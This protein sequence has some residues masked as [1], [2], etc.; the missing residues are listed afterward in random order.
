MLIRRWNAAT[1]PQ[2]LLLATIFLS[3]PR[4]AETQPGL[5]IG[6][7]GTGL[8]SINYGG[9]EFLANGDFRLNEVAFLNADSTVTD[10]STA[11][12]VTVDANL[13]TQ[14]RA[15]NW[16]SIVTS[17]SIV[18]SNQLRISV[19]VNNQT[20]NTIQRIWM[21]PLSVHF[22]SSP[23]EFGPGYPLITDTVQQPAVQ[24]MTYNGGLLVVAVDD[25][26][27]PLQIGFPYS[28]D[29][30]ANTIFPLTLNTDR[31]ASY[32]D[33]FRTINRP[34]PG[35]SS[36]TFLFSL[37]FGGPGS[38]PVSLASDV[39]QNFAAAFPP[40]M[41]WPDRRA[42]ASLH[43]A[44]WP[45]G[46]A[47][48]ATNPRGWFNDPSV[49]VTTAAGVANFQQRLLAYADYSIS[50]LNNMNAQGMITWDIEGEQ[51]PGFVGDPTIMA[52]VAPEMAGIADAY[53]AKFR[54][55]GFRVGV[56]VRPEQVILSPDGATIQE[57]FVSDQL[58][59]L[60]PKIT[61]AH[62]RWGA[63]LFYIDSNIIYWNDQHPIDR[64]I[65]ET[66][67]NLFPDSLFIP[68]HSDA[69]YWAY[70]APYLQLDQGFT[71]TPAAVRFMYPNAFTVIST[72]DGAIQQN[73][74]ALVTAVQQGDVLLFRG[75]F[76]DPQNAL[77]A[78]IYQ[79]AGAS[80]PLV[81]SVTP[82]FAAA[83]PGQTV[84]LAAT[85]AGTANQ[86]VTWTLDS[87]SAGS[88]S[89]AGLYTSPASIAGQQIATVRATS[90]ADGTK[91]ATAS[92]TVAPSVAVSL[93]P[94]G[95]SIGPNQLLQ[96]TAAVAGNT[97]Q[98]VTWSLLS[99]PG[100]L[101]QSGLYRAP[102]SI[103]AQ[104]TV[105][106]EATSSADQTKSATATITLLPAFSL[107]V[108]PGSGSLSAGQTL[109]FTSSVT[110]N[111]N[112]Q[113]TWS[114]APAGLG[115]IS[116]S[117]LYTAPSSIGAQQT[118]TVRATSVADG[119]KF[120]SAT[121]TLNP[122]VGIS[123]APNTGSLSAGQTLQFTPT[124][125]GSGNQQVTWNIAPAGLGIISSS[126]LYQAPSAVASQ[127]SVT[128]RP[129]A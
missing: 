119:T 42:I 62:N 60:L 51:F 41:F 107:S 1:A 115:I 124:V 25:L 73:F 5:T 31:V 104:Q 71:S 61:Y 27:K 106:V 76:N 86:S 113:V 128:I 111:A 102:V 29:G 70:S 38:T 39:Y 94:Q 87:G 53:F 118:V 22:P 85:V 59:A 95:E 90:G 75:W 15:Y 2:L 121:I 14:T 44:S 35:N 16:G 64:L 37:R 32:C 79:A 4:L 18:G 10:G 6:F 56:A 68:E 30:P 127:Q 24:P 105:T 67:H 123:L 129:R 9:T 110:G 81:V 89:P 40:T 126:G 92:I 33:C 21:E 34:I 12:T 69:Q 84:Q 20:P 99:G 88:L 100:S 74:N 46:S 103:A 122:A 47:A 43:I 17:Y 48:Y 11:S 83:G 101:S 66:L 98:Q 3:V 97:N 55:A 36:D 93:L 109:Q 112:Q 114:I 23:P 91:S 77:D 54:N 52:T 82:Q 57:N 65:F 80:A 28:Y 26:L 50:I 19:T 72:A 63:T 120:A 78:S 108:S 96:L 49:D 116:A 117:G 7:S 13:Q 45:N 8:R 58:G 125:T